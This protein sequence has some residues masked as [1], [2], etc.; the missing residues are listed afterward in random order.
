MK[1]CRVPLI[2]VG[3][4]LAMAMAINPLDDIPHVDVRSPCQKVGDHC[5]VTSG[6]YIFLAVRPMIK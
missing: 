5:F 2:R 6:P 1:K 3:R 4:P